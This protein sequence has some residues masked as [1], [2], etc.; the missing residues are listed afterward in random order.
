LRVSA[1]VGYGC[2][3]VKQPKRMENGG[4]NTHA[5]GRVAILDALERGAGR[6]RAI[7][8]Y[9]HRQ[10]SATAGIMNVGAELPE[11]SAHGCRSCMR[12]RH[13]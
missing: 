3:P 11:D 1:D 5:Y 2:Q 8:Y 12:S 7:R 13:K 9:R 6:E 10:L 4:V